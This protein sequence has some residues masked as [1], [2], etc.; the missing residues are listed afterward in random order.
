MFQEISIVRIETFRSSNKFDLFFRQV[1][2]FEGAEEGS[3]ERFN[4]RLHA[5]NMRRVINVL[6]VEVLM[7]LIKV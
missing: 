6:G 7:G 1:S 5:Y 4:S 3:E 2:S